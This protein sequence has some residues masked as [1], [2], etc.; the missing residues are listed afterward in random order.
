MKT[1]PIP[2]KRPPREKKLTR[3]T[4]HGRWFEFGLGELWDARELVWRFVHRDFVTNNKQTILGPLWFVVP[5]LATTIIFTIVFGRIADLPTEG[6][7]HLLFFMLGVIFWNYFAACLTRTSNT[8]SGNSGLFGKVYLPRL[9]VPLSLVI[10]NLIT[11]SVQFVLFLIIFF[12]YFAN[13]ADLHPNLWLLAVPLFLLQLALFG[14]GAGCIVSSLTTY[15]RDFAM[16]LGFGVQLWM[17][18]SCVVYPLSAVSANW[19]WLMALNPIVPILEAIRYGFFGTGSPY[20]HFLLISILITA[21]TL[22]LGLVS[23]K[24]VERTFMDTI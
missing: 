1:A 23:F 10:S 17:Y 19:Q 5:P 11:L 20:P 8:F 3:L 22:F 6:A 16:M 24:R 21:A 4:P 2:P 13:G 15:Y 14:L 12:W 9:S 18:G 7:P